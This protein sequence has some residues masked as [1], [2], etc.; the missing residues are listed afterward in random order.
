MLR[1]RAQILEP[2][3]NDWTIRAYR[4]KSL[5]HV[6]P[7]GVIPWPCLASLNPQ[8]E[9]K[10]ISCKTIWTKNLLRNKTFRKK[11]IYTYIFIFDNCG[12]FF[13]DSAADVY[14]LEPCCPHCHSG[15]YKH[16]KYQTFK[17][18]QPNW[19][20]FCHLDT[21]AHIQVWPWSL[22]FQGKFTPTNSNICWV[23]SPIWITNL[24]GKFRPTG[25]I[26]K[27]P[28]RWRQCLAPLPVALW[29]L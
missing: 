18:W 6:P 24:S 29:H 12:G 1:L 15:T 28:W 17:L 10:K 27:S 13:Q 16:S 2:P 8:A 20:N 9:L 23:K 11:H 26:P 4:G 3:R 25:V 22:C 14:Q 5:R 7:S 21:H 19:P